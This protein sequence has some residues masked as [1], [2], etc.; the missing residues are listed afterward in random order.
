MQ[1]AVCVLVC[2][3]R[4]TN[5]FCC[6]WPLSSD[7]HRKRHV[8][9][10]WSSH[11]FQKIP[12]IQAHWFCSSVWD[13]AKWIRP[14]WRAAINHLATEKHFPR[15]LAATERNNA[16]GSVMARWKVEEKSL[17]L[18]FKL[19][20]QIPLSLPL[21]ATSWE[22]EPAKSGRRL[23]KRQL[24]HALNTCSGHVGGFFVSSIFLH[25]EFCWWFGET[26]QHP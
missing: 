26:F 20:H 19:F 22:A 16:G 11:K 5:N 15:V 8:F 12:S 10:V 21:L 4:S 25:T 6:H 9:E 7:S 3:V 18:N 23:G 14:W 2:L 1:P 17:V 13:T 24:Y